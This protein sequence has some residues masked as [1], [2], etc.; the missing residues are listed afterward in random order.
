MWFVPYL[1]VKIP[2][3]PSS[4]DWASSP[5]VWVVYMWTYAY[6]ERCQRPLS[7]VTGAETSPSLQSKLAYI[8]P[9]VTLVPTLCVCSTV[10][11]QTYQYITDT[12]S[13]VKE[14]IIFLNEEI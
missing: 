3:L 4:V 7:I 5:I 8:P 1:K 11:Y 6:I 2:S 12:A 13:Q 14:V 10:L 9:D